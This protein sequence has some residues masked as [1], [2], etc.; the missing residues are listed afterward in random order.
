MGNANSLEVLPGGAPQQQ[1]IDKQ[2]V[3][4]LKG[5]PFPVYAG[6]LDAATAAGIK[7]LTTELVQVPTAENGGLAIIKARLEMA[8]GRVFE[9]YGDASPASVG[10]QLVPAVIR[11]AATRAKG[12]VLR[13]AVNVGEA[14]QEEMPDG[15][16]P[17]GHQRG[18]APRQQQRAR[19]VETP[20]GS[21][22]AN[23]GEIVAPPKPDVAE[24]R[25]RAEA[26]LQS[27]LEEMDEQGYSLKEI[28]LDDE[29]V[30]TAWLLS[31]EGDGTWASISFE[32]LTLPELCAY[33]RELR[34]GIKRAREAKGA[35]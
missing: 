31:A 33:G 19:T 29:S 25:A 24:L 12:R 15:T 5:K 27:L 9:D 20:A 2:Y 18:G 23:T 11:F 32:S 21:V 17:Q 7:S 3:A 6:V 28:D 8:D 13:D 14:L 30:A 4:N 34:D 35:E 1:R 10:P 16:P 22:N 26:A